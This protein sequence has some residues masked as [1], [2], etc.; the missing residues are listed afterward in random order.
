MAYVFGQ[1]LSQSLT[2]QM[3]REHLQILLDIARPRLGELHDGLEKPLKAVLML[4]HRYW[5]E[6]LQIA[7]DAV[8]LFDGEFVVGELL[9]EVYDIDRGSE[10]FLR[11][12]AVDTRNDGVGFVV[13][14]LAEGFAGDE[15]I[16]ALLEFVELDETS[17]LSE[18]LVGPVRAH[19]LEG[20]E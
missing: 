19:G 2:E 13:V 8:L 10:E 16:S 1:Y 12:L 5:A 7:P 11:L 9:E 17:P 6:A 15:E 4:R 20:G 3:P 18:L 14:L